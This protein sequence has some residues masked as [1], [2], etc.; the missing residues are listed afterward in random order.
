MEEKDCALVVEVIED[1]TNS[2][3]STRIHIT[4][5]LFIVD[6]FF[7]GRR[8]FVSKDGF[9]LASASVPD[10]KS[11]GIFVRGSDHSEDANKFYIPTFYLPALF[12]AVDEYNEATFNLTNK[13]DSE[14]KDVKVVAGSLSNYIADTILVLDDIRKQL[15]LAKDV[16]S[17]HGLKRSLLLALTTLPL[18]VGDCIYCRIYSTN[19]KECPYGA[20]NGICANYDS[21][22]QKM[23]DILR[24]LRNAT[25]KY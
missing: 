20:D 5:Q 14:Q 6:K 24:E 16:E 25:K 15:T 18:D 11:N 23:R 2:T 4:K 7:N 21:K 8:F 9:T 13:K 22:Y 1:G 12:K 3:I 19:C 17:L 10:S